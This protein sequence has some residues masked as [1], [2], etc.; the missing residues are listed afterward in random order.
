[1]G[2]PRRQTID[3][4]IAGARLQAACKRAKQ[5][6]L[7]RA[8]RA[9][10]PERLTDAKIERD[11]VKHAAPAVLHRK[12]TNGERERDH[13]AASSGNVARATQIQAAPIAA[14]ASSSAGDKSIKSC[15]DWCR[16]ALV[17]SYTTTH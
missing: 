9:N 17:I 2:C 7:S 3:A 10:H 14:A 1:E 16:P 13:C 8:I 11:V 15:L 4:D 5:G 6:R 12:V